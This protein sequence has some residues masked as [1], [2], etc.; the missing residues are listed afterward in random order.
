MM[1]ASHKLSNLSTPG[2]L[3]ELILCIP[4]LL[5]SIQA[6]LGIPDA[7]GLFSP[8]DLP[9][10]QLYE[11]VLLT[12]VHVGLFSLHPSFKHNWMKGKRPRPDQV[13]RHWLVTVGFT[14][15]I[16]MEMIGVSIQSMLQGQKVTLVC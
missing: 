3:L 16:W 2:S 10:C 11:V 15:T 6:W 9:F 13:T 5:W 1:C 7:V 12:I 14:I 4:T 8:P